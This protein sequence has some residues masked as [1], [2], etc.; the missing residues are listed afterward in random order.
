MQ[1]YY[2]GL[3]DMTASSMPPDDEKGTEDEDEEEE[4]F[5]MVEPASSVESLLPTQA[6]VEEDEEEFVQA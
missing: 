1:D 6:E 4:A 2:A 5:E 3:K